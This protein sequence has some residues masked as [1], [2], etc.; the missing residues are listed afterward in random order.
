MLFSSMTFLWLFLPAVLILYRLLP[1]LKLKN[2]LLLVASL[3]FY[4]WGE[5][6]YILLMLASIIVNWL[7]GLLIHSQHSKGSRKAALVLALVFNLVLLGYFK[8]YDMFARAVNALLA[9]AIPIKEIALPIGISFYTFQ[10]LSYI[11]DLYRGEVAVQRNPFKLGLYISFFAQLIA[12]PIVNYSDVCG[13]L[14]ARKTNPEKTAYGVKRFI[15]GLGKKVLIANQLAQAEDSLFA[16]DYKLIPTGYIWLAAI[17]YTFQIYYD[18]SG[19][20]DMAIGLGKIFGFDF[21]ENFNYPYIAK[22]VTE[23]WRRWHISLTRWF[24]EYLYIPLGGNRKGKFRTLLNI[25]I[26][27]TLT[28][29][30]H[31]AAWSFVFWGVWHGFF[32]IIERLFLLKWL[33]RCPYKIVN[34]VYTLFVVV[35]GWVFFRVGGLSNGFVAVGA[36]FGLTEGRAMPLELFVSGGVWAAL[37]A[38]VLLCGPLQALLPK[39]KAALYDESRTGLLQTAGLVFIL[40]ASILMLVSGTYNPFIYFRF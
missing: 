34:R 35:L 28:G 4:A 24:R 30:W 5:P 33:E 17:L 13:Q 6:L 36:M 29:L 37:A 11:I 12:G 2:A 19:Y 31:G 15:Y 20:S 40:A 14:S 27:F 16:V 25:A 21:L 8:Y 1:S 7:L 23:F 10:I 32:M 39:F 18:F 3:V 22:S 38:G 26:V 9:G